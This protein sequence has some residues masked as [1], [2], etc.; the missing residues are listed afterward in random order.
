MF[1]G[2]ETEKSKLNLVVVCLRYE[3][4]NINMPKAFQ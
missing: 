1:F 4:A 2:I 3:K